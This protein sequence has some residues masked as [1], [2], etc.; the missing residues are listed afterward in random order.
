MI[1]VARLKHNLDFNKN[2][3]E[4]IEVMKLAATLQFN[5]FRLQR[6]PFANFNV[7]LEKAFL[8]SFP[9]KKQLKNKFLEPLQ[10]VQDKPSAVILVSSDEGFLG[11]LS[12]VLVNKFLERRQ[13][14]D[15]VIVLGQQ[16]ANYLSD[17][18]I[19]FEA[20][21]SVSDKLE[22]KQIEALRDY[23]LGLYSRG[24]ISKVYIVYARFLSIT[25]QQIESEPLLPLSESFFSQGGEKKRGEFLI[26]PDVDSAIESW[27]RLWFFSKLYQIF[28]SSKLAEFAARIMHLE[29]SI[30][31]LTRINQ[32]LRLEYFKYLHALS[33]KTIREVSASRLVR[34]AG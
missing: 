32:R 13:V 12:A 11:E 16:G 27:V 28:W 19:A 22:F 10:A 9:D 31:E 1:P 30:Q 25:S 33:D 24:A 20:F 34:R 5:Q 29:G 14:Q 4:L 8:G 7:F 26:E 15:E 17:L 3:G 18:K 2:L 21:P 23:V 6:E